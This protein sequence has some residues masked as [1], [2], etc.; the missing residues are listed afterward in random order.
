M[1]YS[2]ALGK[3]ERKDADARVR[4]RRKGKDGGIRDMAR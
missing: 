4:N 2:L 1:K 3:P